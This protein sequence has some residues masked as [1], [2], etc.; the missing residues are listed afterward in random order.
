MDIGSGSEDEVSEDEENV[1]AKV[2]DIGSGS[3]NEESED[4]ENATEHQEATAKTLGCI[5]YNSAE[6]HHLLPNVNP[7][8]V[9][10]SLIP[11]DDF[12]SV[13]TMAIPSEAKPN[14]D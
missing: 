5:E 13:D 10:V 14:T 3:A 11:L 1:K 8:Q 12:S 2:M 9:G 7:A 6:S 4:E